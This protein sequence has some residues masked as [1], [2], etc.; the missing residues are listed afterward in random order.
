MSA[1]ISSP[2]TDGDVKP[3]SVARFP[4]ASGR[5]VTIL[6]CTFN[7]ER[8]L[9]QQLASLERQTFK[10]WKLIASD[11]GSSDQTKSILH[12]FRKSFAPGKVNII[13]GPRRGAPANFLFLA[14]GKNLASD[15]YAFCDQD[16]VWEADKLARAI[17]VLEQAGLD[18]PALYGSRT[19]LIDE[20]GKMIGFSPLFPKTPTFRSAL[21]QSIAGGNTM[22]FNQKARDLL[23]FCGA[24]INIP[25]HD[26]WLYQ[27]TSACGGCVR[28]DAYPSVRYR[29]HSQNVIGSN[30]GFAARLRRLR[31]LRQGRFRHWSELNVAALARI[32][33]RMNAE[34]QQI[35][36]LFCKARHRPLLQRAAMF[37]EAGV[38]RQTLLGNLGLAAAVVLNKI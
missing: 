17:D 2:S 9:A 14:C 27:V 21:V 20:A 33:P 12:A 11:D 7:G 16:D 31:M 15:Y 32:R 36:D 22:V 19:S 23:A 1:N 13:D 37:A 35:F 5:T 6:L 24:D 30:M 3:H 4:S 34:N 28:Y 10:N 29:Q 26:W 25:S 8:F 18:V 38:Y